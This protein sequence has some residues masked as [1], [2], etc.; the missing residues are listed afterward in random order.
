MPLIHVVR[1]GRVDNRDPTQTDPPLSSRGLAQAAQLAA[2][3]QRRHAQPLPILSSPLLRCRQT[4][5]PLARA[6][7]APLHIEPRLRELPGPDLSDFP[8][9]PWLNTMVELRWSE[10]LA[11]TE[12]LEPGYAQRLAQ[13]RAGLHA[14]LLACT[15]DTIACSH[16]VAIN[17][18]ALLPEADGAVSALDPGH[19]SISRFDSDGQ[20]LR[21]LGTETI[22]DRAA[23]PLR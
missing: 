15:Q 19:V 7:N 12:A 18:L 13:W 21:Y 4:I 17:A 1:H 22:V 3:L 20:Q 16:F 5:E 11:R 9:L 6:W 23:T 2:L 8:R 10:L 14:A